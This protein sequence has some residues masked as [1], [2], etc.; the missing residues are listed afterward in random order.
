MLLTPFQPE[1]TQIDYSQAKGCMSCMEKRLAKAVISG[2]SVNKS[3]TMW[4]GG[5][6]RKLTN[7]ETDAYKGPL[8]YINMIESYV[9]ECSFATTPL[10]ICMNN[11]MNQPP[12]YGVN[13]F[14][15]KAKRLLR[16]WKQNIKKTL[17]QE[18]YFSRMFFA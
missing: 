6:F 4:I 15:Y 12:P 7:E 14:Y 10:R 9:Q 3:K 18:Y 2:S 1:C 5:G 17:V 11:S 16:R 13:F 8:N